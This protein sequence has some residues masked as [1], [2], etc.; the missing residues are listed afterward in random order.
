MNRR[1]YIS[2]DKEQNQTYFQNNYLGNDSTDV[3]KHF[4]IKTR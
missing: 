4:S 3:T 2:Y 1:K